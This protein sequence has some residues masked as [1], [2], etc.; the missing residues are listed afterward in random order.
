MRKISKEEFIQMTKILKE[1]EGEDFLEIRVEEGMGGF[2][3][4]IYFFQDLCQETIRKNPKILETPPNIIV[5][6]L[7]DLSYNDYYGVSVSK[8]ILEIMYLLYVRM[9]WLDRI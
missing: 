4:Y 5:I 2:E 6:D 8:D 1:F 7:E 3:V 9:G